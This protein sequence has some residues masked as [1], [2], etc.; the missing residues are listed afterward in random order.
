MT[1]F[2]SPGTRSKKRGDESATISMERSLSFRTTCD[3]IS[4]FESNKSF[5]KISMK[6]EIKDSFVQEKFD[7]RRETVIF[8]IR[9]SLNLKLDLRN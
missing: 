8:P 2:D 7:K 9:F 3:Q 5:K 1:P 4:K 6:I